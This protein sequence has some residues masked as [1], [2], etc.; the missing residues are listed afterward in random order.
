MREHL[1]KYINFKKL[2]R[3]NPKKNIFTDF[4]SYILK[5]NR[6]EKLFYEKCNKCEGVNKQHPFHG[7]PEDPS[8]KAMLHEEFFNHIKKSDADILIV[9]KKSTVYTDIIAL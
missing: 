3:E 8:I 2:N 1:H 4:I 9:I 5:E 7:I 6:S